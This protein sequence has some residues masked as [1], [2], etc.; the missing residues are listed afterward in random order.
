MKLMFAL[1][2]ICLIATFAAAGTTAATNQ[3]HLSRNSRILKCPETEIAGNTDKIVVLPYS[4]GYLQY[5][6]CK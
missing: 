5:F 2:Y 6:E 1:H 4:M 3:N